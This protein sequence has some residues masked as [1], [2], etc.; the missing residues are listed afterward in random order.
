[1]VLV[2]IV[3]CG[4]GAVASFVVATMIVGGEQMARSMSADPSTH[5]GDGR[6]S[7]GV[8]VGDGGTWDGMGD[9]TGGAGKPA[10]PS[11]FKVPATGSSGGNAGDD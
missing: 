9:R 7:G 10:L 11:F 6:R 2:G 4:C 1:V 8:D 3:L 5:I